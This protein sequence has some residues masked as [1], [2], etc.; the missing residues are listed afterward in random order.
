MKLLALILSAALSVK[1]FSPLTINAR[2]ASARMAAFSVGGD[3]KKEPNDWAGKPLY[4]TKSTVPITDQKVSWLEKQSMGDVML[5]PDYVLTWVF[6]LLGPLIIWY[7]TCKLKPYAFVSF[8]NVA[9]TIQRVQYKLIF[10]F[11]SLQHT[12][13]MADPR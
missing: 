4:K 7:H 13:P 2:R 1:G 8:A 10:G 5:E 6:G 9:T 3:Q 11:L 12:T